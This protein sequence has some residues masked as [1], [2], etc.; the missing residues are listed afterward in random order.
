[1]L[2]IFGKIA[3]MYKIFITSEANEKYPFL[4]EGDM[5]MDFEG[6]DHNFCIMNE[7]MYWT[8]IHG[9]FTDKDVE[10][11]TDEEELISWI[12]ANILQ[13]DKEVRTERPIEVIAETT[14]A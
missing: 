4:Q 1:M 8:L 11:F 2:K 13:L 14:A 5:I 10:V 9:E 12:A 6:E 7:G 3:Q